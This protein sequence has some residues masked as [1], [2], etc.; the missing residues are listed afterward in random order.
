MSGEHEIG[1]VCTRVS[2]KDPENHAFNGESNGYNRQNA[3]WIHAP[4][5]ELDDD[6][7]K[8]G[9]SEIEVFLH[10]QRP[11]VWPEVRSIILDEKYFVP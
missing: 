7:Q 11:G 6:Q 9:K 4:W 10:R 1:T 2:H 5:L 3:E 8:Y